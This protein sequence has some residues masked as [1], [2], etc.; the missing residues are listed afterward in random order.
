MRKIS[1]LVKA[2][3]EDSDTK[4]DEEGNIWKEIIFTDDAVT[5]QILRNWRRNGIVFKV[6]TPQPSLVS[7]EA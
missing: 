6:E 5:Q 2:E 7:H 1:V 4:K 3:K